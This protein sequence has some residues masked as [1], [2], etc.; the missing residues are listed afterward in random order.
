MAHPGVTPS[1]ASQA[2][3]KWGRSLATRKARRAQKSSFTRLSIDVVGLKQAQIDIFRPMAEASGTTC[4][5]TFVRHA[6]AG[7]RLADTLFRYVSDEFVALLN[8]TNS[9]SAKPMG[10]LIREV[11]LANTLSRDGN[12][13]TQVDK[14]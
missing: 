11:V 8:D 2:R 13:S 7:L 4:Y 12:G 6:K 9:A 1:P 10:N 3:S 14:R 5:A